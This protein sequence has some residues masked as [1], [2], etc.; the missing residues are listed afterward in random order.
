[1]RWAAWDGIAVG[2]IAVG[3]MAGSAERHGLASLRVTS[4]AF[5]NGNISNRRGL[6]KSAVAAKSLWLTSSESPIA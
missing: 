4:E 5:R 2:N 6:M 3:S 1:M